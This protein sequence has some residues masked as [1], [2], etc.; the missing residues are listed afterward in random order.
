MEVEVLFEYKHENIIGL[1]GYCGEKILVYEYASNGSL[2]RHLENASL[3]W[4]ERL[5]IGIDIATGLDF[6]HGGGYP[7]IHRDVKS[8]NI[9]LNDDWKAKITDF[10]FSVITP[11]NNEIDLWL[12]M[13]SAHLGIV[14]RCTWKG[15]S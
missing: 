6:L 9:L 15:V 14:T 4:T 11:L 3:T 7:V 5:K 1:V 10:G 13:L 2:D 12:I 8:S